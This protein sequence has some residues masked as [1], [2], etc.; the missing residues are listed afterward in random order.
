MSGPKISIYE[1]SPRAREIVLGQILC[2]QESVICYERIQTIIHELKKFLRNFDKYTATD[3]LLSKRLGLNENNTEELQILRN[4]AKQ[5]LADL[6]KQIACLHPVIS[7]KYTV[8]EIVYEKKRIELEKLKKLRDSA[9]NIGSDVE[10]AIKTR[11]DAAATLEKSILKE[12]SLLNSS[13]EENSAPRYASRDSSNDT[14]KI[15]ES[16]YQDL[17]GISSFEFVPED[18]IPDTSFE[19]SKVELQSELTTLL[20]EPDIP[21]TVIDE[22]NNA[23]VTLGKIQQI[24]YLH[25]F[26]SVTVK[27]ILKKI[28]AYRHE[29]GEKQEEFNIA[30]RR[31]KMLCTT[32]KEASK[33]YTFSEEAFTEMED[34]IVRLENMVV[35]MQEQAYVSECVDQVMTEMGY[36]LIGSREVVKKKTGKRFRNELFTFNEGTAVN[37]TYSSEGQISMELGGIAREDRIPSAEEAEMLTQDMQTFCGEFAEF[38]RRLKAKGILVN[39]RIALSP[40]SVEYAAIIN[41]SDYDVAEGTQITEMNSVDRRKKVA[42]RKALRRTE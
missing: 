6:E 8:S 28:D 2:E 41:V 7:E 31:Y 19:D 12:M 34:E 21:Q 38:E 36:D 9:E 37:V 42:E 10:A 14:K 20:R 39:H 17:S 15:Q 13:E 4:R 16:I 1:L 5:E 26:A 25:S 32:A 11:S 27:N 23:I 30:Y 33:N 35:R 24:E 29:M 3:R 40:P 18:D 22:I